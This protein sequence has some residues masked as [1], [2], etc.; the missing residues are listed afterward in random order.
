MRSITWTTALVG[1][2][3]LALGAAAAQ[4]GG[5]P[6]AL[7]VGAPVPYSFPSPSYIPTPVAPVQTTPGA[8]APAPVAPL[9]PVVLYAAPPRVVPVPPRKSR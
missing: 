1:A 3:G 6:L 4:A 7:T 5:P 9:P 8:T 2:A